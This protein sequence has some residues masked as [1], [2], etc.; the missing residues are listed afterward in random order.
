M[1][2]LVLPAGLGETSHLDLLEIPDGSLKNWIMSAPTSRGLA[3]HLFCGSRK[4]RQTAAGAR[5]SLPDFQIVGIAGL[6]G[7]RL[8]FHGTCAFNAVRLSCLKVPFE[9]AV[10][11]PTRGE[12]PATV[13][14]FTTSTTR[15]IVLLGLQA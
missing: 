15:S 13:Q 9:H 8:S 7:Y 3:G 11:D 1:V 10:T 2:F 5:H 6:L 4:N 12:L 14:S